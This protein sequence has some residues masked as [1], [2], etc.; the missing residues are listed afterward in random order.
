MDGQAASAAV[1]VRSDDGRVIASALGLVLL[2]AGF[3]VL[4]PL[5]LLIFEPQQL[6]FA[7]PY[8]ETGIPLAVVGVLLR[9]LLR[10]KRKVISPANG[11]IVV[12]LSWTIVCVASAFPVMAATGLNFTQGLF[13]SV[14]GWTTTGL[15]LVDV[16]KVPR[17]L[18]LW[19]SIMQLAGGAGLAIV[20]LAAFSLPVGAGIY[21]AEGKGEQLVPSVARSAKIVL[22]L[23]SG[24]AA[25]GIIAYVL[26]GMSP[27]D[28]VNQTF[29]A[30][31]TGGFSTHSASIGYWHSPSVEAVT[32]VLMIAGNLNFATAYLLVRGK[33]RAFFL[34]VE[35]RIFVVVLIIAIP[36]VL[37][38][39]TDSLYPT[40]SKAVRV[41]IFETVSALTTTGFSTVSYGNWKGAGWLILIILMLIGGGTCSTAGGLKQYRVYL[42]WRA[43]V[44]EIRRLIVPSRTVH[45]H[46]VWA[47]EFPIFPDQTAFLQAGI[48]TF[49]Y[50]FLYFAGTVVMTLYGIPLKSA[51]FEFASSIGTV[52]LSVGVTV[53]SLPA[54]VLWMQIFAMFLGR[55]EFF[56][57]F[58][59][60]AALVRKLFRR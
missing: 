46:R 21:R 56:V 36:L 15:S 51:L 19:R 8:L 50:L 23:Y 28:A 44:W 55:L 41:A 30:I 20:M 11:M 4:S 54:P 16:E 57:A 45:E 40:F 33:F 59:A 12:F 25:I 39:V 5:L 31:S 17:I 53:P 6:R 27:F 7:A 49:M 22:L 60:V 10:P 35:I 38:F 14:S 37:L 1:M 42:L 32:I 2:I 48:F 52:G 18:L 47:G 43:M 13:E 9:R 29:A 24:Y 58:G 34:N 26:V 3:V